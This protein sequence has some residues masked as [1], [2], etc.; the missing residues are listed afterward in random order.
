[1]FFT[2]GTPHVSSTQ[3]LNTN[4]STGALIAEIDS[5]QVDRFMGKKGGVN[6]QVHWIVGGSTAVVWRLEQCLSTGLDMSTAGRDL[7]FAYTPINQSGEYL[8]KHRVEI[9]DRFRARVD[10]AL[11]AAVVAAKIIIEPLE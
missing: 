7:S 11:A 2:P 3:G 9:G 6:C 4:P 8:T 10:T 1:M 5:T